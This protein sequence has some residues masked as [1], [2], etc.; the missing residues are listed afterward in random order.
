[1]MFGVFFV[2]T[3]PFPSLHPEA[4][5]P[6]LGESVPDWKSILLLE[7]QAFE[8]RESEDRMRESVR[9]PPSVQGETPT[10][11]VRLTMVSPRSPFRDAPAVCAGELPR[12]NR[13][14]AKASY[15]NV[16]P[17]RYANLSNNG[18]LLCSQARNLS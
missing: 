10:P 13:D 5:F 18:D 16:V 4:D 12:S 3:L 8:R 9:S 14:N 2:Q 6:T 1:M 15:A 11:A 7:H 17:F